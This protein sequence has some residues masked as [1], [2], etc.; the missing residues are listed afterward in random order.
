M[1]RVQIIYI[2]KE[3]IDMK[4]LL[5]K[6]GPVLASFALFAT[7]FVANSNCFIYAYQPE[8]PEGAKKLRKYSTEK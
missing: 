8:L 2:M 3:E 7:T 1:I 5:M 6:C 4:K